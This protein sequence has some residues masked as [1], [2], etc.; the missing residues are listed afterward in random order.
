MH[1][2]LSMCVFKEMRLQ[3]NHLE[4]KVVEFP[5]PVYIFVLLT[6]YGGRGIDC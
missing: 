1:D 4:C 5:S 2:D 3:V 6:T